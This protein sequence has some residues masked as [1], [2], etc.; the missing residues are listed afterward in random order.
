MLRSATND[1]GDPDPSFSMVSIL[2]HFPLFVQRSAKKGYI[3]KIKTGLHCLSLPE[4][5]VSLLPGC[6]AVR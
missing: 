5:S 6:S 1:E 3:V 4:M 2:I